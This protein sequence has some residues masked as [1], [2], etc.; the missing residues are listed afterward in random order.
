MKAPVDA[1][2]DCDGV[3][4]AAAM[5]ALMLDDAAADAATAL[6]LALLLVTM[7]AAADADADGG[8][9]DGEPVLLGDGAGTLGLMEVD[10]VL[11]V[12]GTKLDVVDTLPVTLAEGELLPV[13]LAD[14]LEE[15]EDVTLGDAEEL[16]PLE[17]VDV[18]DGVLELEK[19]EEAVP[20]AVLV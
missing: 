7:L 19:P 9:N 4:D 20:V 16:K 11:E 10:A 18:G 8:M 6:A 5:L 17:P 14:T 2:D 15:T 3:A 1:M 12:D 13:P